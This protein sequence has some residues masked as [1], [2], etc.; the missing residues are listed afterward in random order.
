MSPYDPFGG[1]AFGAAF[2]IIPVIVII[3]FVLVFGMILVSAVRGAAQWNKNNHS[4]VLTVDAVV[5]SKRA[6]VSV[7]HHH[8]GDNMA[9]DHTTSST[10][11]Y[12][13]FEVPSGDRMEFSMSGAEYGQLV[14][15]DQGRL[16]FQGTRYKGF[17]R[18]LN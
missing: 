18:T 8:N 11:Y 13:T 12:V 17:A 6:D 1:G 4:P 14:E 5:R 15:G 2:S 9:M 10:T 16:T 7:H 3:G